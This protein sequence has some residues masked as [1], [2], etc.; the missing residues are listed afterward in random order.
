MNF[1]LNNGHAGQWGGGQA[2]VYARNP[3]ID[4][5]RL[6]AC[7]KHQA[8]AGNGGHQ[9]ASQCFHVSRSSCM[10]TGHGGINSA[11]QR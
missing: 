6:G 4:T 3:D 5:T 8:D 11:Q 7:R 2:H 9:T 10:T 1:R